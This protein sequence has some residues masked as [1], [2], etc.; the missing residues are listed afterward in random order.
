MQDGASRCRLGVLGWP[1]A[2]S[3]SPAMHN[4]ALAFL[5]MDAWS[6]QRLPVPPALFEQT[7][8][9]L[10]QSGFRGA[11]V[12]VPHKEAA[13]ALADSASASAE[14]IGAANTLTFGDDG[15]V[16]AENTDAP[17]L[18]AALELSPRGMSA[19]I[20]GAGG[21]ARAAAWALR[22]AGAREVKVWNRTPA[23][24]DALARELLVQ[25]VP[26][27]RAADLLINCTSVGLLGPPSGSEGAS[28]LEPSATDVAELNQLALT[29][30]LV[31]EY[32][33]V[34]DLVYGSGPTALVA[35]ARRAGA[36][37][38]DGLEVLVAQGALS[39]ETWTGR[40]APVEVMR[41]AARAELG[42]GDALTRP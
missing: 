30:D 31:G 2:H 10:A 38:L 12:T 4:A 26:E 28:G 41:H 14:E 3:R 11:N 39:F 1:V 17:G 36:R 40:S 21:S 13:L 29:F 8:R 25:S 7:A 19:Q 27:P 16:A 32:S 37:A 23:R 22:E 33:H 5:G 18:L 15:S 24:A 42:R 35:A 34:I 6:Y 20:L 9:A